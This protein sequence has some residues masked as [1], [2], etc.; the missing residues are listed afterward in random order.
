MCSSD[1]HSVVSALGEGRSRQGD[2]DQDRQEALQN[3]HRVILPE[4]FPVLGQGVDRLVH[5]RLVLLVVDEGRRVHL[6]P[7]ILVDHVLVTAHA[8]T[9]ALH[10]VALRL[11]QRTGERP[12]A[13]DRNELLAVPCD[14]LAEIVVQLRDRGALHLG[15]FGDDLAVVGLQIDGEAFLVAL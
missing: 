13:A 4:L 14:D 9:R 6:R 11:G 2:R 8:Q 1:L 12:V 10:L 3:R 7:Q 15:L 5:H